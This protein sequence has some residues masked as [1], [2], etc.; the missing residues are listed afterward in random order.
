VPSPAA[1]LSRRARSSEGPRGRIYLD[2]RWAEFRLVV[3]I[4]GVQHRQGVAVSLDNLSR[5]SVA[6]TSDT[7]LRID[8]V[9]LRLFEDDFMD[10]VTVGLGRNPSR[11]R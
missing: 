5:N 3:E 8:L 2:V 7:V 10:Q 9:G 1:F 4:D 6:L 11:S